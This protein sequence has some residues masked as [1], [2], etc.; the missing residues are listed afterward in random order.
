MET[1]QVSSPGR[2]HSVFVSRRNLAD[3]ATVPRRRLPV[4]NVV[5]SGTLERCFRLRGVSGMCFVLIV[6][7][8]FCH[9]VTLRINN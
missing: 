8:K 2:K 6:V 1:C 7:S 4:L 9:F 3:E 5:F